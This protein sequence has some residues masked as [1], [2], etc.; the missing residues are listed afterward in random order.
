MSS[1]G[2]KTR[3]D[4]LEASLDFIPKIL[5]IQR[6]KAR[7]RIACPLRRRLFRGLRHLCRCMRDGI[8]RVS[9]ERALLRR[10]ESVLVGLSEENTHF[11][12]KEDRVVYG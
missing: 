9:L 1:K 12:A 3:R 8:G 4:T 7:S 5:C 11:S 10:A 2:Q 6:A